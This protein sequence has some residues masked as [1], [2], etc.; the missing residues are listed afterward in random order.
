MGDRV[1]T[2]HCYTDGACKPGVFGAPGGWGY[3]L[4]TAGAPDTEGHGAVV[5][6]AAKVM[7]V[8]AIAEAL[9]MVPRGASVVV[10]S[11]NQP[12]VESLVK[13]LEAWRLRDFAKADPAVVEWLRALDG[14][15][16][17]KALGVRWQWVRGHAGNVGNT[18]ADELAALG[19]RE[20]KAELARVRPR[21]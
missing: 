14:H 19:A 7:E 4:R 11:D 16:V 13:N 1:G 6:T 9:A 12:L 8:R 3:V 5:G 17:G 2:W 10:Y 21:S 20:A 18:R 15:V